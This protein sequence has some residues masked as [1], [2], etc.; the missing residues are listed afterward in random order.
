MDAITVPQ[1]DAVNQMDL[2]FRLNLFPGSIKKA[3]QYGNQD[4][5]TEGEVPIDKFG[6]SD[7]W[8]IDPRVIEV[9]P[10][11]NTRVKN[12]RYKEKVL[13]LKTNMME[14]GFKKDSPLSVIVVL[15]EEGKQRIKLKRGHRRLEAVLGAMA[16]G[17]PFDTV[18]CVIVKDDID[19][20]SLTADLVLS[21][22]G[23]PLD[24]YATAIVCKR[25]TRWHPDNHAK[26]AAKLGLWPSQVTDYLLLI[27]GP[28][29]I[30]NYVRDEVIAFTLAV[31]L[32]KE[33]GPKALAIIEQ[34][35]A[36]SKAA[37]KTKLMPRF[38]PGKVIKKAVT[39]AAPAMKAAINEIK[40]DRAFSQL[41]PENQ[42]KLE[43]IL[44]QFKKAEEAE[45]KLNA[46]NP[47]D[48]PELNLNQAEV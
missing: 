12:A 16:E 10:G 15:D 38:V 8:N 6:S 27:N 22:N 48:E 13:L 18:P 17:K 20:E 26:I 30:S 35:L 33:H 41:S 29:E 2:D 45:A 47:L 44:E 19:E 37:G 24:P 42:Q 9:I 14:V 36:R 7:L 43:E 11:Y 46:E 39:A 34:S 40:K 1:T 4:V 28:V 31:E 25:M 21:N 23:D 32:L 5:V 3:M